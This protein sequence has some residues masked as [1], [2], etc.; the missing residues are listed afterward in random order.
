MQSLSNVI[1]MYSNYTFTC[2]MELAFSSFYTNP[3]PPYLVPLPSALEA[4]FL[5]ASIAPQ[6]Q[7]NYSVAHK[8]SLK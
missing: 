3:P 5:T 8:A 4:S 7:L 6:R 1:K 2:D